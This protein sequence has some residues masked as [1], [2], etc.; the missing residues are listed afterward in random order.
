MIQNQYEKVSIEKQW[1]NLHLLTSLD[2]LLPQRFL[3]LLLSFLS[4]LLLP[5]VK[6]NHKIP[7]FAKETAIRDVKIEYMTLNQIIA[8]E[9]YLSLSP[10]REL[11]GSRCINRRRR[12]GDDFREREKNG[13]V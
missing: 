2:T 8:I 1:P 10:S 11:G 4:S 9:T 13:R 3:L 7:N 5:L 6:P 12:R